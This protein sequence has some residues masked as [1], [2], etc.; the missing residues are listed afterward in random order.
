MARSERRLNPAGAQDIVSDTVIRLLNEVASATG[1]VSHVDLDFGEGQ[2][3]G[4]RDM[5]CGPGR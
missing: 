2:S 1:V 5:P 3:G 4:R